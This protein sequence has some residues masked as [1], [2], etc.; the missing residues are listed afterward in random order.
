MIKCLAYG[1]IIGIDDYVTSTAAG[2]APILP[3]TVVAH[4]IRFD[5]PT[6]SKLGNH[7]FDFAE[8]FDSK[9]IAVEW[10]SVAPS[11]YALD[12]LGTEFE[13]N[14]TAVYGGVSYPAKARVAVREPLVASEANS[15]V[16]FENV[17]LTDRFWSPKQRV[18]ALN[19]ID[20]AIGHIETRAGGEPN[21]INSI[22]KLNGEPYEPFAGLVFSD[23]DIYKQLEAISYT[24]LAIHGEADPLLAAQRVKLER[25]VAFWISLI[26]RVQY[27]DGYINTYFTLR[28]TTAGPGREGS[29]RW[30]NLVNHET[31]NLGHLLEA[32]VAYTRYREKIGKPD[33]SLY[34]VGKRAA[35]EIVSLFG[36]GG[37]R[38]EVPGHEEVE[39]ALVKMAKLAEEYEGLGTG[40]KYIDTAKLLIDRR[41][42]DPSL[43]ETGY[44]GGDYTQDKTPIVKESDAVG[45][46]VRA[47][48]FY[49]GVTDVATLL[50]EGFV[51]RKAYLDAMDRLWDCVVN[52]K[53]YITGG[54][55]ARATGESFG[56]DYELP[57]DSSY[58]EVCANIALANWN[59]RMNLVHE[60]A[61]YADVMERAL[62]NA[63]L[64]GTN[65]EGNLFYYDSRLEVKD[66]NPRSAWF[67]CACC[68]PNLMR[69]IAK[70]SEYM[71]TVHG[72]NVF[73]NM[74]IGS[75]GA[76]NISGTEVRICQETSYPWDG[77]VRIMVSPKVESPEM[78]S[79]GAE[80]P[81]TG[82][83]FTMN[84]RIPG[85]VAEQKNRKVTIRVN[86][87]AV[88]ATAENGYV[89]VARVWK[90]GDVVTVDIPMEIRMTEPDPN[91]VTNEGRIA[92]ER[93]PIV[94]CM[95][96]A[97]NA[98]LNGEI[99]DF[100][101]LN[102]VVPKDANLKAEYNANL[103]NGVVEITGNVKY[104]HKGKLFDAKLQAVP[105]YAWNNRGDDGVQGQNCSSQMLIW[106][107]S[108]G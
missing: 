108:C 40:Q 74:Y 51:D 87:E 105:Y 47:C 28:S 95:E 75:E 96:K 15:A 78:K 103:L 68:P 94:Y 52:R 32:V 2:R 64:V 18:N 97:G 6:P 82:K 76:L 50:P 38:H 77:A 44:N 90:A 92:L 55:G 86:G 59:Q 84:I 72:D 99:S 89:A 81:E 65:L 30:Y 54:I 24:L 53:M 101:P 41:G 88:M 71:Y 56:I 49:A 106:T 12:K 8:T 36:P 58:V 85:W 22:K 34:V 20:A 19:S 23:T 39:M 26:E 70:L 10:E 14:G 48:Y 35:D 37:T 83:Y 104:E 31:Y 13:V 43:R 73:V 66:G 91:V 98:Q 29:H 45:H 61:K 5:D 102:F 80:N 100:S 27:A 107:R 63:V 42:E 46:A 69:T 21:F 57:N 62:Y 33:Y 4:G 16:T 25:K 60:D 93:G 9:L 67:T 11:L 17:R 1:E 3:G 79:V 7:G